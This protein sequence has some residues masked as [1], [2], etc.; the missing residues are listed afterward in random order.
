MPREILMGESEYARVTPLA[1]NAKTIK[2]QGRCDATRINDLGGCQ[3][4]ESFSGEAE[5]SDRQEF[6]QW[7]DARLEAQH[8][9]KPE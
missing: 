4:C 3:S 5:G 9:L 1:S 8:E 2:A 7:V 6:H